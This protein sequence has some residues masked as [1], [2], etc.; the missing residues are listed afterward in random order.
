MLLSKGEVCAKKP[1]PPSQEEELPREGF[2]PTD[3]CP[4]AVVDPGPGG[5]LVITGGVQGKCDDGQDY[6]E[7]LAFCDRGNAIYYIADRIES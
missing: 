6:I 5:G 4:V 2:E 3:E 1:L 7:H